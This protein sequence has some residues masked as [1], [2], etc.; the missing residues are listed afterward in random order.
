MTTQTEDP[1]HRRSSETNRQELFER[2]FL[3]HYGPTVGYGVRRG[4]GESDA[5]EVAADALKVV[6]QKFPAPDDSTIPFLYV[7][8]RN[9]VMHSQREGR[10]RGEAESRARTALAF[11]NGRTGLGGHA[12]LVRTAV[13]KLGEPD[14]EVIRLLYWDGLSAAH[15]ALIMN[16]AEKAIWARA[17]RALLQLAHVLEGNHHEHSGSTLPLNLMG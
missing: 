10:R 11:E 14:R 13:W 6:W 15:V 8:C 4:L 12:D 7:T 2:F 3:Q 5:K 17:S 16:S 9:L 1:P